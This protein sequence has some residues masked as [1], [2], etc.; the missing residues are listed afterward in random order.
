MK[1]LAITSKATKYIK[2]GSFRGNLANPPLGARLGKDGVHQNGG[3]ERSDGD[4]Q[5]L[6]H[7]VT[8]DFFFSISSLA[9]CTPYR[10]G[11]L[12]FGGSPGYT[13]V[14]RD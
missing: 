11:D 4:L 6:E 7:G 13:P 8:V 1:A 3:I 14:C 9:V 12:V 10:A 2:G 5:V